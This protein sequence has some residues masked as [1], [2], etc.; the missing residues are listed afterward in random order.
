MGGEPCA[1]S[2]PTP[3]ACATSSVR[4]CPAGSSALFCAGGW[5]ECVAW[6]SCVGGACALALLASSPP[7]AC[8]ACQL[9]H[10]Q[11]YFH[12]VQCLSAHIGRQGH[13]VMSKIQAWLLCVPYTN[14]QQTRCVLVVN[15]NVLLT[16]LHMLGRR[17]HGAPF[18]HAAIHHHSVSEDTYPQT[19]A[20]PL[21][22]LEHT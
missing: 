3:E 15:A 13:T 5:C 19:P 1:E 2:S 11:S 9:T 4:L 8:K 17:L 12:C 21:D 10:M 6:A 22:L 18:V 7:C 16:Y 20:P 14:L